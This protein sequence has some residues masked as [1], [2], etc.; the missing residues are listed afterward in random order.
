MWLQFLCFQQ[1]SCVN[2]S[3]QR[4]ICN[5]PLLF[6]KNFL[7][8]FTEL[9]GVTQVINSV[10][11]Q[12]GNWLWTHLYKGC[13]SS[14][15]IGKNGAQSAQCC[16]LGFIILHVII[17]SQYDCFTRPISWSKMSC[18]HIFNCLLLT[19]SGVAYYNNRNVFNSV[20]NTE[21][22]HRCILFVKHGGPV[23]GC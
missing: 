8:S 9:G 13:Q 7:L 17:Y 22:I 4:L 14:Q 11:E 6:T 5:D 10:H 18:R 16:L 1:Q 3:R 12:K 20:V 21:G 19:S 15:N 2:F 23:N